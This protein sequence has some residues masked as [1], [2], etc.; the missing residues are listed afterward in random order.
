[1]VSLPRRSLD[2]Q[3]TDI[4]KRYKRGG[5]QTKREL[6]SFESLSDVEKAVKQEAACFLKAA[7]FSHTYI[8]EALGTT[9][10][11]VKGWFEGEPG[12]RMR[13]HVAEIQQDY[14]DGAVKL[15]K[16]YAIELI[17]ML[18]DIARDLDV[19]AK[20]RIQAITEAL[21]RAGMSKVNKS[22][23]AVT[24][25][26]RKEVDITDRT[27]LVDALKDAPPEVQQEVARRIDEAMSLVSEHTDK[28][29]THA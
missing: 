21:D 3:R 5:K 8:A 28:D 11:T 16:T 24:S 13:E 15:L 17:E 22:Q 4:K 1:M 9:R 6:V 26:E 10:G 2:E 20:T 25:T 29:V 23:S 19:D 27:G 7:D 14:I 18:V 12:E